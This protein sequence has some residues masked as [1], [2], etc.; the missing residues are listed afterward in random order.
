M[1]M[2]QQDTANREAAQ[3][4]FVEYINK[5]GKTVPLL[6]S[7]FVARQVANETMKLT[8]GAEPP[9]DVPEAESGD[10]TMYDHMERLRYLEVS[11]PEEEIRVFSQVLSSAL[12]GLEQFVTEE[13]HATLLGKMAYNAYGV[14]FGNGRNDKVCFR[15]KV[16][17]ECPSSP[18]CSPSPQNDQKTSKRHGHHMEPRSKLAVVYTSFQHMYVLIFHAIIPPNGVSP[19]LPIHVPH[20]P[21]PP[22]A[23]EH[24]NSTSL[25]IAPSRKGMRSL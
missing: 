25:P 19:R 3:T 13:R 17:H 22:L 18:D 15:L 9:S 8:G 23:V 11:A 20:L 2:P 5:N 1:D 6:V 21:A 7:R 16:V 14:C 10:Y 24:Q 12:P 4:A